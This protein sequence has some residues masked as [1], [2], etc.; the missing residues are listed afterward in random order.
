MAIFLDTGFY[1]GL[2]NPKDHHHSRCNSL[3]KELIAG[4]YG[5]VFTSSFI[6]LETSTLVA[7]RTHRN[8]KALNETHDLFLGQNQLAIILHPNN[9]IYSQTWDLF[10][11][12]NNDQNLKVVSFVDC[13]NIVFCQYRK[14]DK[15]L[16][17]DHHFDGWLHRIS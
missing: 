15:I 17:F 5:Q 16:A 9:Q 14:I 7:I 1:M 10:L 3:L 11:K 8:I 4:Q 12:M 13:A 2:V 6:M